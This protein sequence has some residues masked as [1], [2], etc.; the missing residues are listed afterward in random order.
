MERHAS[1]GGGKR[2]GARDVVRGADLAVKQLGSQAAKLDLD[3]KRQRC[4]DAESVTEL[5]LE[6]SSDEYESI[7][8][9]AYQPN[10]EIVFVS[11]NMLHIL[12]EGEKE[13]VNE[14]ERMLQPQ[15]RGWQ[16]LLQIFFTP[17]SRISNAHYRSQRTAT[18]SLGEVSVTTHDN[19]LTQL[20]VKK[21]N[22]PETVHSPLTTHNSLKNVAFTLAEVLITLGIIGV[23]AA[24]TIP[25]L[26]AKYQ[27]KEG[28]VALKK[29]ISVLNQ[30]AA[31]VVVDFGSVPDCYMWLQSPYSAM[32]KCIKKDN[33]GACIQWGDDDGNPRPSDYLGRS[34]ECSSYNK[35]LLQ[36]LK[37]IKTCGRSYYDGC[38]MAYKGYEDVLKEL[39]PQFSDDE[40]YKAS[41]GRGNLRAENIKNLPAIV[42]ADGTVIIQYT[43]PMEIIIDV[44]GKRGPNKWGYDLFYVIL[45][46]APD[47]GLF[48]KPAGSLVEKGGLKDLDALLK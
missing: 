48:Y 16:K 37:I 22:P 18:S 14:L 46:G 43:Y 28:V 39:N 30:A 20:Q 17:L 32:N 2:H 33:K 40:L 36:N 5:I 25:N 7:V 29:E 24:L 10:N 19:N 26:I 41:E 11:E 21:N 23:V 15:E 47:K 13:V 4:E 27:Q 3:A 34:T 42:L 9:W 12:S 38:T 31:K 6:N 1:R 45:Y 44:N 8:G 35:V